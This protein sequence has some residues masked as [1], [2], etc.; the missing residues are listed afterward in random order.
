M[1]VAVVV[2]PRVLRWHASRS[3]ARASADNA[4]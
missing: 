3:S 4:A 1:T 2:V